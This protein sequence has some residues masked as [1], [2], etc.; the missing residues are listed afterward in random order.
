MALRGIS[1]NS[2]LAISA[3]AKMKESDISR[4]ERKEGITKKD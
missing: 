3:A 1:E 2:L 4:I